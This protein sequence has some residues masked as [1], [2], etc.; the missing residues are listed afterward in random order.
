MGEKQQQWQPQQKTGLCVL[1]T[2]QKAVPIQETL[3]ICQ[4]L[5]NWCW[6]PIL[7]PAK[8]VVNYLAIRIIPINKER[9]SQHVS[10]GPHADGETELFLKKTQSK[11]H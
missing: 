11:I 10:Y 3:A 1:Y 6:S 8:A 4:K 2:K 7:A 9:L 5:Q